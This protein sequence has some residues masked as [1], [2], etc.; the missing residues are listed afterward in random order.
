MTNV[1]TKTKH[2]ARINI[3]FWRI[4][5]NFIEV[6]DINQLFNGLEIHQRNRNRKTSQHM[7]VKVF[8]LQPISYMQLLQ[9]LK[10][11]LSS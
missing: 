6:Y 10:V 2:A 1:T 11:I 9:Y 4:F 8:C 5:N 7:C 3:T